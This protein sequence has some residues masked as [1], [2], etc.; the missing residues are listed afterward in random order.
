MPFPRRLLIDNE[1]LVVEMRPHWIAL[2]FPGIVAV[3]VIAGW[4]V[5]INLG[6][7]TGT[8]RDVVFW[9]ALASAACLAQRPGGLL[10]LVDAQLEHERP[11]DRDRDQRRARVR[12]LRPRPGFVRVGQRFVADDGADRV[13]PGANRLCIV[14]SRPPAELHAGETRW[15]I[16]SWRARRGGPDQAGGRTRPQSRPGALARPSAVPGAVSG[17][18]LGGCGNCR[19]II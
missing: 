19:S 18:S 9:G 12:L 13:L 17:P 15:S 1:E 6:P 4:I 10:E 16:G 11:D 5:G 8:G 2:V 7:S 3:L 14:P